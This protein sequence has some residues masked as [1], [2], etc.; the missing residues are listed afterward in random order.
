MSIEKFERM[1]RKNSFFG[2]EKYSEYLC[3]FNSIWFNMK[4]DPQKISYQEA[5]KVL[6]GSVLP[7]PIAFVST[8]DENGI[9]NLAPF[10]F[11]T[12]AASNP[13]T[14]VFCPLRRGTDGSKKDTLKNIEATKE[15]VV[16]VVSEDFAEKMNLTAEEFPPHV[17]EF[18]ECGF[19]PVNS[20]MIKA[21]RVLESP[22]SF[23]CKLT[24]IVEV[25]NNGPGGGSI[26]IG[27]IVMM[28]IHDDVIDNYR[29]D[30]KKTKPLGRLAGN[31]YSR[32][33]DVFELIRPVKK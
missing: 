14:L 10:S 3:F 2:I 21:N 22:V 5:Y 6:I 26:V 33:T 17:D 4:I 12:V 30:M 8:L 25:G 19:T 28:H 9:N 29:I 1:N 20:E 32:T 16:N 18:K 15:F 31:F 11:F 27:E 13:P 23:E 7:R 24:Q